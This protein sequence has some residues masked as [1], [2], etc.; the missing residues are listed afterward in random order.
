MGILERLTGRQERSTPQSRA[1]QDVIQAHTRERVQASLLQVYGDRESRLLS[2]RRETSAT[3]AQ[4]T[5]PAADAMRRIHATSIETLLR[6]TEVGANDLLSMITDE[7]ERKAAK[8]KVLLDIAT[9]FETSAKKPDIPQSNQVY[10][11]SRAQALRAEAAALDRPQ[12]R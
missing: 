1:V 10:A 7:T 12:S 8:Q 5:G 2:M 9:W 11:L 3:M 6:I 4:L